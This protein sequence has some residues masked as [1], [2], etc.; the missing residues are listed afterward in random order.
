[1]DHDEL[2]VRLDIWREKL[3]N[4]ERALDEELQKGW[5]FRQ[6]SLLR[7][8]YCEKVIC[9]NVIFELCALTGETVPVSRG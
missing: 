9:A 3:A 4:V 2:Q 1:M 5:A 6:M 7:F 8:L